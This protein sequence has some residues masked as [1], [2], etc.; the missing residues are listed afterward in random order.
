MDDA[1]QDREALDCTRKQAEQAMESKPVRGTPPWQRSS[2]ASASV[3]A[4]RFLP[5]VPALTSLSD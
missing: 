5:G 4:S 3:P 1:V 2:M